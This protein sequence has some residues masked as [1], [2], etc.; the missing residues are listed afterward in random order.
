[1]KISIITPTYNRADIIGKLFESLERQHVE[2]FEWVIIDDGSADHTCQLVDS[3]IKAKKNIIKIIYLRQCNQGKHAAVNVGLNTITG[4]YFAIVDSD[5]FLVDSCLFEFIKIINENNISNNDNI[6]G[7]SGTK[8]D[9]NGQTISS[10]S[11][12]GVEIMTHLEWFYLLKRYG[13]RLDLCKRRAFSGIRFNVFLGE[14]FQTED[15]FWLSALGDKLFTNQVMLQGDYLPGGLTSKA[16][17]LMINSPMGAYCFYRLLFMIFPIQNF[18]FRFKICALIFFYAILSTVKT[19][20]L[21]L[22]PAFLLFPLIALNK[23][24]KK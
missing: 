18:L 22:I 23:L 2:V 12:K 15:Y 10:L 19:I 5:D 13:D 3:F 7:V 6:I 9:L 24:L 8:I 4:D 1:M 21:Y 11:P 17:K 14:K 20:R 16:Q